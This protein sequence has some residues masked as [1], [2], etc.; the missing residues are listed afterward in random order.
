[1]HTSE[2]N[3]DWV[4]LGMGEDDFKLDLRNKVTT[5]LTE[6]GEDDFKLALR[7]GHNHDHCTE[8]THGRFIHSKK[9]FCKSG[10]EL[11]GLLHI[12]LMFIL[13][14]AIYLHSS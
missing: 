11:A 8:L 10:S 7:K 9:V 4:G 6:E 5:G 2:Q 1:M 13:S 14:K 12:T 3:N